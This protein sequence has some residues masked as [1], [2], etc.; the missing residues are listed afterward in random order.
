MYGNKGVIALFTRSESFRSFLR[1]YP[2]ISIIVGIHLFLWM[3]VYIPSPVGLLLLKQMVGLNL[4]IAEGEY[5]RLVTPIIV[6]GSFGHMLFNS[7]S[8]VLFGPALEKMLGKTKF[9]LSYVLTGI[10]ANGATYLLEPLE[11]SH[12]G[13]SG[14]I[15]GLFGIYVYMVLNRKDLID[16]AN[17]QVILTILAIGLVMT[18]INSNINVVAHIFGLIGGLLIAPLVLNKKCGS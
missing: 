4:L 11:F 7:F 16:V 6:H 13:S 2:I 10:F 9:I 8:L 12:V 3:L 17:S 15:F 14:A 18:F 5:W 1:L